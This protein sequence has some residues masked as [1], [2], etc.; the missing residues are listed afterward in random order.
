MRDE[1]DLSAM[2]KVRRRDVG[3]VVPV[4]ETRPSNIKV[5]ISI[6]LDGDILE[7]FKTKAKQPGAPPYQTQ[8]NNTLRAVIERERGISVNADPKE[9][10]LACSG[11]F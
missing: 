4:E 6:L 11:S 3:K 2:K 7:H 1:Y 5:R 9:F 8:I 10:A